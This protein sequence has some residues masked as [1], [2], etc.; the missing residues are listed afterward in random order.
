MLVT[1]VV[2]VGL[3]LIAR[4]QV[5]PAA[6]YGAEHPGGLSRR[7]VVGRVGQR[8]CNRRQP[9]VLGVDQRTGQLGQIVGGEERRVGRTVQE[10]LMPQHIDQQ[11][12][13][14]AHTVDAAAG[15]R[16]GQHHRGLAAG[17][18]VRDDF[19]QHRVVVDRHDRPVDDAG[20]QPDPGALPERGE[21]GP[22]RG[23]V[24]VL[25]Q[26]GLGLPVLSGIL[27]VQPRLDRIARAPRVVQRPAGHR[28]RPGSA[29]RPGRA[30]WSPR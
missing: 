9:N 17:R 27:G 29:V 25:H 11:I 26:A 13:V 18:G 4:R 14:G 30:R 3:D 16:V 24:D 21:R 6:G 8:R 20:V 19:G 10:R 15:Q 12:A 23:H 28:R 1:A 22:R 2:D 5:A 7:P